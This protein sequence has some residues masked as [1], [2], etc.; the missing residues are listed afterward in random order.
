MVKNVCYFIMPLTQANGQN[1][2]TDLFELAIHACGQKMECQVHYLLN[3]I[4]CLSVN[5]KPLFI[6]CNR[7]VSVMVKEQKDFGRT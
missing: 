3:R 2:L 7:V 1:D 5:Y 6:D 4:L